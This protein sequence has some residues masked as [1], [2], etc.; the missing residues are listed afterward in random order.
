MNTAKRETLKKLAV[1]LY[2]KLGS[3]DAVMKKLELSRS[4]VYR[5][6]HEAGVEL[7][8]RHDPELYDRRKTLRGDKKKEAV[9]DYVDGMS[10]KDIFAKYGISSASLYTAIKDAG[11][12]RRPHGAQS[13]RFQGAQG[14]EIARMYVEEKMSQVQIAAMMGCSQS[15]VSR[16]LREQNVRIEQRFKGENHENWIGG[17]SVTGS[18]YIYAA[19]SDNDPLAIMRNRQGY[20]L[21]HRLMMS[22]YLGRPL[23]EYESVHHIDGDRT[24]NDLG[25]LQLRFSKHGNGQSY[26]CADCGSHH[27]I[28]VELKEEGIPYEV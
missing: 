9:Q 4:T 1:E 17:K 15:V 8:D 6:L 19:V 13:R 3:G 21:E 14:E 20:V 24:N 7:P 12:P 23:T 27:I 11:V 16:V 28:A 5:L 26:Q 10:L 18:G 2:E 22:R 25:N